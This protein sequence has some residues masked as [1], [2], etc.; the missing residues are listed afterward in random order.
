MNMSNCLFGEIDNGGDNMM[1]HDSSS[2]V[3]YKK[4][5]T[6]NNKKNIVF[7]YIFSAMTAFLSIG[8]AFIMKFLLEVATGKSYRKLIVMVVITIIFLIVDFINSLLYRYFSNNYITQAVKG[9]KDYAFEKILDKNINSFNTETTSR[10]LS[11]F[12][13]DIEVIEKSYIKGS[14]EIVNKL[15][16][17]IGG[18]MSMLYMDFMLTIIVIITSYFSYLLSNIMGKKLVELEKNKSIKNE[19][20]MNFLKNMLSGFGVIKSFKSELEVVR[21]FSKMN[22]DLEMIKKDKKKMTDLMYILAKLVA[23]IVNFSI[24]AVGGYFVISGRST[25]G[26]IIAFIQLLNYVVSPLEKLG[27]LYAEKKAAEVLIKKMQKNTEEDKKENRSIEISEFVNKIEFS[28]VSYGF[29]KEN[30]ILKNINLNLEHN[31]SYAIVGGSGSGKS[32]LVNLLLGY[33]DKYTG[34]ILIDNKKIKDIKRDSL[35]DLFSVI[36][37]NV[38]IFDDSIINNITMFRKVKREELDDVIKKSGLSSLVDSKGEDYICGEDGCNL[39]GGEKQRISIARCMIRKTPIMLLDE[40]TS[41]LDKVTGY[42]IER[43]I[44]RI[45]DITKIV[46]THRLDKAILSMYDKIIVMSQGKIVEIG[47]FNELLEKKSYFY[48]L[49]NVA[50]Y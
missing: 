18:L 31:K 37:Q 44:L 5:F 42:N 12:S 34:D 26:V 41:A 39:S 36:Q 9:Y 50:S 15:I 49:Y 33:S 21:S 38:F 4:I 2:I 27:P 25:I 23:L 10:Y 19:E 32:T 45:K 13:N 17:L 48:S 47:S 35:Y 43:D 7:T 29:E 14:I 1:V 30:L 6:E 28:N 46:V 8:L 24:F 22:E 11:S 3:Q 16:L 40:A 20:F